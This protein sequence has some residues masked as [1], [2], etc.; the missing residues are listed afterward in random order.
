MFAG[1]SGVGNVPLCFLSLDH[2]DCY[3]RFRHSNKSIGIDG[4][5]ITCNIGIEHIFVTDPRDLKKTRVVER[6]SASDFDVPRF[7]S[8]E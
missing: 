6:H 4:P 7:I 5:N 8:K 3:I 1:G 2:V